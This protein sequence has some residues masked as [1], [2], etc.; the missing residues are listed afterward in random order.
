MNNQKVFLRSFAILALKVPLILY[1]VALYYIRR[2]VM[3][4]VYNN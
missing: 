3:V 1:L 4:T 2:Y